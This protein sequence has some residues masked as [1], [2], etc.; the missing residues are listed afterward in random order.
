MASTHFRDGHPVMVDVGDKP[1]TV[2]RAVAEAVVVLPDE[3]GA[4][5]RAGAPKGDPVQ[6]AEL[7]GIMGAKRTPELIPLAHPLPLSSVAVTGTTDGNRVRFEASCSTAAA[8]GVEMEA[9]T[10]AAVAAL[11]LYDMLKG[12]TKGIVIEGVR[13]L[14]KEGGRSGTWTRSEDG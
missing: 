5:L 2:R 12:A 6:V 13:L 3:A 4:L 1:P 7:A 14:R 10:A 11:T 8:T 9:L